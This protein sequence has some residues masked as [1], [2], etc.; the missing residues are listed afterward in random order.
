[1]LNALVRL[2]KEDAVNML[3]YTILDFVNLNLR[4]I[5][6]NTACTQLPQAWSVPSGSSK[7]L[8]NAVKFEELL[9]E[10]AEASKP[11]KRY[12]VKGKRQGYCATPTICLVCDYGRNRSYGKCIQ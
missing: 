3:L 2:V 10:K 5:P 8:E 11:N 4:Q 6:Q 12:M 9:F 1:M 7:S